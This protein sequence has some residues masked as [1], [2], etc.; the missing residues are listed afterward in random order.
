[1]GAG[2]CQRVSN[3]INDAAGV[4]DSLEAMPMRTLFFQCADH[5]FDH[6]ILLRT[7]RRDELLEQPVASDQRGV[8]PRGEHQSVVESQHKRHSHSAQRPE[9][10][11]Q[12]VLQSTTCATGARPATHGCSSQLPVPASSSYHDPPRLGTGPSP[13]AHWVW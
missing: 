10:R 6:A 4:L 12:G 13:R 8:A 2:G 5:T 7:V 3:H 11:N 1:M 9:A